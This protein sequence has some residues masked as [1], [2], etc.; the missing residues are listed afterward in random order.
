MSSGDI[1][2]AA[3]LALV[4]TWFIINLTGIIRAVTK[5]PGSA[6]VGFKERDL[7]RILERCYMLFPRDVVHFHG[8]TY[9]R[10]MTVRVTTVKNRIYEGRL[11]GL[12]SQDVLCVLTSTNI[13]ANEL[14]KIEEMSILA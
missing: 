4:I 10:G 12:N 5:G 11:I 13:V 2:M 14:D 9:K 6:E 3:V 8:Q 1:L 7:G